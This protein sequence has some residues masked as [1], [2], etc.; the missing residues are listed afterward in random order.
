MI[1]VNLRNQQFILLNLSLVTS[2]LLLW[3]RGSFLPH[4][5]QYTF[6]YSIFSLK[7]NYDI[8]SNKGIY[9]LLLG[10]FFLI[11]SLLSVQYFLKGFKR[12]K[13]KALLPLLINI[14]TIIILVIMH[15]LVVLQDYYSHLGEREAI[16]TMIKSGTLKTDE[17]QRIIWLDN[18]SKVLHKIYKVQLPSQYS[19]LSQGGAKGGEINIITNKN[20]QTKMIMF[21]PSIGEF[22][23]TAWVYKINT[24]TPIE[25]YL[26][27]A[28]NLK[29]YARLLEAKQIND[30]WSWVDVIEN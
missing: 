9:F 4:S 7:G 6:L 15:N 18:I 17:S 26:F 10:T 25:N 29:S 24:S 3:L 14:F 23:Y 28:G 27:G 22:N 13:Y 11:L 12:Y 2:I 30:N 21:F 5:A 8:L 1:Q 20:N 16:V 19:H